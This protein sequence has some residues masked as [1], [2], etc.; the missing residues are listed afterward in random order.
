MMKNLLLLF[1]FF[2]F[3]FFWLFL[4]RAAWLGSCSNL[5]PPASGRH[6]RA[7][8]SCHMRKRQTSPLPSQY[9]PPSGAPVPLSL[10]FTRGMTV[11]MIGPWSSDRP[12]AQT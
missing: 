10:L 8:G 9:H 11:L 1:I 12:C 4:W 7:F 2:L 6:R 5:D 3:L